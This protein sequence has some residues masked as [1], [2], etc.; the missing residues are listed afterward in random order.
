M[1]L[2]VFSVFTFSF[3]CDLDVLG[4]R[5]WRVKWKR[6]SLENTGHT[7]TSTW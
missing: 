7:A 1:V 4:G 3:L 2:S 5:L 6:H